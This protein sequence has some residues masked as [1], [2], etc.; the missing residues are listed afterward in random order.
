MSVVSVQLRY[1]LLNVGCLR[2]SQSFKLRCTEL[3]L[4][5]LQRV[6]GHVLT[7]SFVMHGHAVVGVVGQRRLRLVAVSALDL[8]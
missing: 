8:K 6:E 7:L 5:L 1:V 3:Y 4:V 2:Y